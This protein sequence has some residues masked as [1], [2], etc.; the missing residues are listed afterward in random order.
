[1]LADLVHDGLA[2]VHAETVKM[3]ARKVT[4]ARLWITDAGRM[5]IEG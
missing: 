1:M 5:A 4:V 2:R 3:D